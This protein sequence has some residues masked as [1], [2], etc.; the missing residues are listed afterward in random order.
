MIGRIY[1]AENGGILYEPADWKLREGHYIQHMP[2][3][4]MFRIECNEAALKSGKATIHDFYAVLAHL[5]D[6]RPCPDDDGLIFLGRGAIAVYLQAI[7]AWKPLV[8]EMAVETCP[9]C[10]EPWHD[11]HRCDLS[12]ISEDDIPF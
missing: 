11:G 3:L 4:C 10:K 7:G 9:V 8:E 12:K 2:T 6:G 5:C 1:P